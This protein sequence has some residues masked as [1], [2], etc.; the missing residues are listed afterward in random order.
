MWFSMICGECRPNRTIPM[1]N[2][3]CLRSLFPALFA[4]LLVQLAACGGSP[5]QDNEP[6]ETQ[7]PVTQPP[8][9]V[10]AVSAERG[11]APFL[12][13]FSGAKS[14]DPDG[15]IVTYEWTDRKSV[16]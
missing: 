3:K 8:I 9:A 7:L 1:Q 12:V 6:P 11:E 13:E 16:V 14:S 4:A 5:G 2:S 10:V 15:N